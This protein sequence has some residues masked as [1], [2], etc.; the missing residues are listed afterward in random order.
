MVMDILDQIELQYNIAELIDTIEEHGFGPELDSL[1]G[2]ELRESGITT[3]TDKDELITELKHLTVSEEIAP[4]IMWL[5]MWGPM[6]YSILAWLVKSAINATIRKKA[7]DKIKADTNTW[8]DKDKELLVYT[9]RSYVKHAKFLKDAAGVTGVM[10]D[11]SAV[12]N[13]NAIKTKMLS[14]SHVF[15]L[16]E[17][18]KL[19]SN[20]IKKPEKPIMLLAEGDWS[21]NNVKSALSEYT[22]LTLDAKKDFE[23]LSKLAKKDKSDTS[24]DKGKG[25]LSYVDKAIRSLLK[26]MMT[27]HKELE[28]QTS[29]IFNHYDDVFSS[30][31]RKEDEKAK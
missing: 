14:F 24:G 2:A 21:V 20:N 22:T 10:T 7:L 11:T 30:T 12:V 16:D 23:K 8:K 25:S 29:V 3:D 19:V 4:L 26:V 31:Y 27:S 5:L 18:G 28:R 17:S 6:V 15:T 13:E 1:F 9:Y